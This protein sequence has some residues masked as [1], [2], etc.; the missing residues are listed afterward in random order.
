MKIIL[1]PFNSLSDSVLVSLLV[2][3]FCWG[4]L[5]SPLVTQFC[6][7]ISESLSETVLLDHLVSLLM[8]QF[9]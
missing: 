2:T 3:Q 5:V 7:S 6:R 9:C 8:T 4:H 1:A